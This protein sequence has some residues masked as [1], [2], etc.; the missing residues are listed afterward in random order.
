MRN[1]LT[2]IILLLI[3]YTVF[4]TKQKIFSETFSKENKEKIKEET[5]QP[6]EEASKKENE[7]ANYTYKPQNAAE[8]IITN[9][10]TSFIKSPG[11]TEIAKNILT[12]RD[13]DLRSNSLSF[14]TSGFNGNTRKYEFQTI[15]NTNGKKSICGQK[16]KAL[17]IIENLEKKPVETKTI[18]YVVGKHT[19]KELNLLANG[20]HLNSIISC[21][22]LTEEVG[23]KDVFN[24]KHQR[25]NLTVL[26][27]LTINDID[28]S[29]IK[30]FDEYVT[31][32]KP[33]ECDDLAEFKYKISKVN[34]VS[35]KKGFIKFRLGDYSYPV[36][37]SYILDSMPVL[38]SR[39]IILPGKYLRSNKGEFIFED[40]GDEFILF[41]VESAHLINNNGYDNTK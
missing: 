23:E 7:E 1:S 32:A 37:L 29:K 17:Y 11:G 8:R 21:N 16:I 24:K 36:V 34:G 3:L 30:I 35:L 25:I 26:E 19:T 4:S 31:T 40:L 14:I 12:P 9:A 15:L 6:N 41:E 10:I 2:I 39:T 28:F 22:Y 38:G 33:I 20:A 18:E 13:I 5:Q 27:H